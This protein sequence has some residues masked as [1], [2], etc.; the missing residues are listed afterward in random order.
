MLFTLFRTLIS[1]LQSQ[2]ALAMENLALRHQ[3]SVLQR[4]AKQPRLRGQDRLLWVLLSRVWTGWRETLTIVQPEMVIRWHR[5]GFRLYWRWKSRG[6]RGR[7]KISKEIRDLIRQMSTAN[8]LWGAPRIHG[9]LLKLGTEVSQA[10]VSKYMVRHRK[11]PSQNWQKFLE[12]HAKEIA[13]IDFFT[14]PTATFRVLFVFLIL[15]N[16]RRRILHF[17]V[18][19]NPSA[20]WTGQQIAEAFP[21]DAAPRYL[22]RDR[23]GIYGSDFVRRVEGLGIEGV[24]ISARSP[25]QNPYVERMIGSIRRGCLDHVIVFSERHLRRVLGGYL[26]YYH[27]SR[28]HLGLEKDCPVPRLIEPPALGVICSEPM[29]GGLQRRYFRQAA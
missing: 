3:L 8:P 2:R 15:S 13:S 22:V 29:V 6:V 1:A 4:T 19:T 26:E 24:P 21:W 25:W 18:T 16:H 11:P 20:A 7:P 27:G 17:N 10:A 9:E 23:D 5:E 28:T 14:V 12:N